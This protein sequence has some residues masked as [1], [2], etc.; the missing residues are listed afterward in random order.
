M[1]CFWH[2]ANLQEREQ[3]QQLWLPCDGGDTRSLRAASQ[4]SLP[5][6]AASDGQSTEVSLCMTDSAF[7]ANG[8]KMN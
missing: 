8:G 5:A 7:Q 3:A 2:S 6:P 1:L 4:S